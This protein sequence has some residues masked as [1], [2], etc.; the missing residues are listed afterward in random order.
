MAAMRHHEDLDRPK[1]LGGLLDEA[2]TF[3]GRNILR[4]VAITLIPGAA[5][6]V[7]GYLMAEYMFGFD[8]AR[9]VRGLPKILGGVV[10]LIPLF[11]LMNSTIAHAIL[12]NRLGNRVDLMKSLRFIRPRI[13]RLIGARLISGLVLLAVAAVTAGLFYF[14]STVGKAPFLGMIFSFIVGCVWIY[15]YVTWLFVEHAVLFESCSAWAALKRS[16]AWAGGRRWH[17]FWAMLVF[18]LIVMLLGATESP[19]NLLAGLSITQMLALPL[20]SMAAALLY[21]DTRLRKE[22]FRARDILPLPEGSR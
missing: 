11:T 7:F 18:H 22:S 6:V 4:V 10:L 15:L 14:L 8:I 19:F 1:G 17:L 2:F 9:I 12:E 16:E 20:Y 13:R 21:L 3:Y 5:Y